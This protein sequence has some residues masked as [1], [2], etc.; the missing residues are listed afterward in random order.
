MATRAAKSP[1]N[2]RTKSAPR[3]VSSRA[4]T[5]LP[6]SAHPRPRTSPL[7]HPNSD[8]SVSAALGRRINALR[9]EANLTLE[10]LGTRCNVSRAMLSSIERGDK[11]PTFPVVLRIAEGLGI[12][13]SDLLGGEMSTA[14]IEVIRAGERPL[15]RDPK[16]GFERSVLSP[17]HLSNGVELIHYHIPPNRATPILPPYKVPTEK[18]IVVQQGQ[19]TV[20]IDD[21]P[22][23]LETGDS[24]YFEVKKPYRFANEDTR[25]A[26]TYYMIIVRGR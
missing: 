14:D 12:N 6:P 3:T 21:N 26:C 23:V 8:E 9:K 5:D 11:S 17:A 16:M 19:L 13:L 15:Y 25:V 24:I 1:T 20:Y 10:Q 4:R 2:T 22:Y 7:A 18:Y